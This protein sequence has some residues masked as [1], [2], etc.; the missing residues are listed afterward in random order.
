MSGLNAV[1]GAN[2]WEVPVIS[3]GVVQRNADGSI[4][5]SVQ[6]RSNTLASLQALAGLA[7]EWSYPTDYP[8]AMVRHTGVAGGAVTFW[9]GGGARVAATLTSVTYHTP[10]GVSI[11]ALSLSGDPGAA[12]NIILDAAQGY[13]T[14]SIFNNSDQ[15]AFESTSGTLIDIGNAQAFIRISN[16]GA[17]LS[18]IAVG[19]NVSP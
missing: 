1:L 11:G 19:T 7:G 17:P 8:E 10:V 2:G 9:S 14:F 15:Q 12:A 4:S 3:G 18:F 6:P 13:S 5:G 16:P